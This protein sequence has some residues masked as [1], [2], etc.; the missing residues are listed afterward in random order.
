MRTLWHS[1]AAHFVR[2]YLEMV[3]AMFAG[4]FVLGVPLVA[5]LGL[6]GVDAWEWDRTNPE[7]MLLGMALVMSVPM[8]AWMRVRGHGWAPT[9]EMGRASCRERVFG[10]V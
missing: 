9:V 7:L 8:A 3:T 4:M 6:V 1:P 10:Y 2:H 5:A